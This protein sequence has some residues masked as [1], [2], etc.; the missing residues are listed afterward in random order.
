MADSDPRCVETLET[1]VSAQQSN[2]TCDLGESFMPER[3]LFES[4]LRPNDP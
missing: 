4:I 2:L 3:I 1:V